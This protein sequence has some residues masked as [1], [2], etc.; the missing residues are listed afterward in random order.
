MEDVAVTYEHSLALYRWEVAMREAVAV[1]I[2]ASG[3]LGYAMK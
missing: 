1:G 2:A 3:G